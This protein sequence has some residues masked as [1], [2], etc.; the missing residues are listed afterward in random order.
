MVVPIILSEVRLM[1]MNCI[2]NKCLF[3]SSIC[4]WMS[5]SVLQELQLHYG[6]C[7]SISVISL[8]LGVVHIVEQSRV[9][10][11]DLQRVKESKN[12]PDK[13]LASS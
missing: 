12:M 7:P 8:T 6:S 13:Y 9:H 2:K 11:Q 4:K 1:T 10:M 5:I 3:R